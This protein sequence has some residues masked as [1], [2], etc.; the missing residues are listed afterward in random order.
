ME[1]IGHTKEKQLLGRLIKSG[2]IPH[3]ILFSGPKK[4]GKKKIAIEF[5]KSIFCTN[6]PSGWGFCSEC[7]SCR[8]IDSNTIPDFSIICPED[9][10][11]EIKIEQIRD[12]QEKFCLT[13]FSGGYKAGI[14]D[15]AHLMNHHSQNSFLKT[16]EE[17]KGKTV[18]VLITD[19]P[20]SLLPTI[21]SRVQNMKFSIL[22]KKEIE[23]YL[24][25]LGASAEKA[26]GISAI[27]SGQI[28]KAIDY[29]T[30]PE[31]K[32][33]FEKIISDLIDLKISKLNKKFAYSKEKSENYEE[34]IEMLEIWERYFRKELL[35][36]IM[37]PEEDQQFNYSTQKIKNIIKK[38]GQSKYLIENTNSSKKLVLDEL[39]M[40]L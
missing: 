30:S 35:T 18:L 32:E 36:K 6:R 29:F 24:I 17:P 15:D 3:A 38:I 27:S 28:G 2:N 10:S 9:E 33:W 4:I 5:I 26:K 1:S 20:D 22:P 40:E 8:N 16:L 13:S 12:L 34:M 21:N 25:T 23:D 14:V 11:K 39:V 19:R 31:K 37:K 7:Y